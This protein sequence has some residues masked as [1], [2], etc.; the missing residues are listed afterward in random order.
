MGTEIPQLIHDKGDYLIN[1]DNILAC[2]KDLLDKDIIEQ[3]IDSTNDDNIGNSI[4]ND[5]PIPT[6]NKHT[7]KYARN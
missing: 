5:A 3:S 6:A 7:I 1:N 2:W 4:C